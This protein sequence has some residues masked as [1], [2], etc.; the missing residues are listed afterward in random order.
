M[1]AGRK[2][3]P[4][5][6]GRVLLQRYRASRDVGFA[7]SG[8]HPTGLLKEQSKLASQVDELARVAPFYHKINRVND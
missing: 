5:R 6:A 1:A 8:F 3:N 7:K 2:P 4:A